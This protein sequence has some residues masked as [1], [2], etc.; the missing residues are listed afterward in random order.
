MVCY[1]VY[2]DSARVSWPPSKIF[3]DEITILGSFSE[4]H[5]FPATIGYLDTG[6]VKVG[7]I[8]NKTFKLEQWGECLEAMRN[9]SAIKAAI[10][11]D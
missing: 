9:K 7:G 4:T 5:M 1:G 10:V 8:V 11:F 3:G 6:K 2:S